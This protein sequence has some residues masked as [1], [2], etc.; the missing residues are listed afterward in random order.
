MNEDVKETLEN[1]LNRIDDLI[2]EN[3]V[4]RQQRSAYAQQLI[5]LQDR[6]SELGITQPIYKDPSV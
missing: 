3:G 6:I 5:A 4:L 2:T 1:Y